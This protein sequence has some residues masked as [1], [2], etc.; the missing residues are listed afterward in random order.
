MLPVTPDYHGA[1]SFVRVDGKRMVTPMLVVMVAIGS[2]DLLF[3]LDS[4]PRSS[5]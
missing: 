1:R 4:I 5:G 3:A 2:T